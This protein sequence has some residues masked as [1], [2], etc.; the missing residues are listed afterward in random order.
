MKINWEVEGPEGLSFFGK[1]TASTTHELNNALGTINENAGLLEDLLLLQEQG[2]EVDPERWVTIAN[3]ITA[4]VERAD[5]ITRRLNEFAH[6]VDEYAVPVDIG[7]LLDLVTAL[8]LRL[9]AQY[10]VSVE[11]DS[12]TEAVEITT[13]PF[14][15]LHLVERCLEFAGRNTDPNKKIRL[16]WGRREDDIAFVLLSGLSLAGVESFPGSVEEALLKAVGATIRPFDQQT[17]LLLEMTALAA[18]AQAD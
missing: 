9:L 3:R 18:V 14:L 17:G 15:F 7:I 12:A 13:S 6:T 2:T 8:S 10:A 4:Q 1:I 16:T 5:T 11:V